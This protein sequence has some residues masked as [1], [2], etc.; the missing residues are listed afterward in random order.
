MFQYDEKKVFGFVLKES[1]K[2]IFYSPSV[3]YGLTILEKVGFFQNITILN[4]LLKYAEKKVS[5]FE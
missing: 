4:G 5:G 1:E 2:W 3:V